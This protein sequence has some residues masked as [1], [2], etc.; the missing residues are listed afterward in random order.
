MRNK[1][2]CKIIFFLVCLLCCPNFLF[3]LQVAVAKE[4]MKLD[5]QELKEAKT[6]VYEVFAEEFAKAK[7]DGKVK[8]QLAETLLTQSKEIKQDPEV[9]FVALTEARQ[10]AAESGDIE[11]AF[12]AIDDL[13][14]HFNKDLHQLQQDTLASAANTVTDPIAA[15]K[16]ATR[17]FQLANDAS[18]A[19]LF[20][21]A[22]KLGSVAKVAAGKAEN[23]KLLSAIKLRLDQFTK[24]SAEATRMQP[25]VERINK[26][27]NDAEANL[28]LGKS[29]CFVL[30]RFDKGLPFLAKGS[31]ATLQQLAK[32]DL[33]SPNK[34]EE[35]VQLGDAWQKLSEKFQGESRL[36]ILRRS[37]QWYRR[38]T[39]QLS[40]ASLKLAKENLAKL[41]QQLPDRLQVTDITTELRQL[42]GHS[43]EV[44][45]VAFSP[46]GRKA[47]SCGADRTIR[48]WDIVSGKEL[49]TLKGHIAPVLSVAFNPDGTLAFSGGQDRTIR[50]WDLQTG[51]L[52]STIRA[53]MDFVNHVAVSPD[54]KLIAAAGQDRVVRLFDSSTGNEIK[55]LQGHG[56]A[57]FRL[58]YSPDGKK[59]A[60]CSV[61]QTIR[62][63]DV[64]TGKEEK[65]LRGHNG[66]VLSVAFS[67]D[68]QRILSGSEDETIRLWD[69]ASGSEIQRFKGHS[70]VV[71]AVAV[72]PDGLR[73]LSGSDDRKLILWHIQPAE[74]LR[75]LKGHTD[76][77]YCI[78]F[79]P[80]GSLA[81][82]CGLDGTIRLWGDRR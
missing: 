59:L 78:A 42:K 38:A 23:A 11:T 55:Q 9:R 5:P 1:A 49:M 14:T 50:K 39:T 25:F 43:A 46:D 79:S 67:P 65:Q 34:G 76:A 58:A 8:S 19:D 63:W 24:V 73:F 28:N 18:A 69:V 72:S 62:I 17:A 13:V 64:A 26:N 47:L 6:L 81:L 57:I 82:S 29:W 75:E 37:F 54:G 20:L 61:D 21:F 44:L 77:I 52:L 74:K 10:L 3:F 40:D 66:E 36:F 27:A 32:Q 51:K 16:I 80:D 4:E 33:N 12:S 71:G 22:E 70:A 41:K 7:S 56:G 35:Q 30:G 53:G 31:D 45:F 68:G 48:Y 2:Q 60:T 15:E